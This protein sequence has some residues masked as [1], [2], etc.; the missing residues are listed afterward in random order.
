MD[1]SKYHF[2]M[3]VSNNS[4]FVKFGYG[5]LEVAGLEDL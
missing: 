4:K 1:Q 2:H 3:V 5:V